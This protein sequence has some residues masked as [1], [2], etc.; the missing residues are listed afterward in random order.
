MNKSYQSSGFPKANEDH[1]RKS[2]IYFNQSQPATEAKTKV[3]NYMVQGKIGEGSYGII[4]RVQSL[5]KWWLLMF[6]YQV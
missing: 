3:G 2:Q 6:I 5:S 4:F 1:N